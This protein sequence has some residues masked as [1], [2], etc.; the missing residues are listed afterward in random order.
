MAAQ[1][2]CMDSWEID[3]ANRAWREKREAASTRR[4]GPRRP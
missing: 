4:R 2:D 1:R 3:E